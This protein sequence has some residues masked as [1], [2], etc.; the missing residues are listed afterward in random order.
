MPSWIPI[1][2]IALPVWSATTETLRS[3][4]QVAQRDAVRAVKGYKS[5]DSTTDLMDRM[6]ITPVEKRWKEHDTT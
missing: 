1:S 6:K 4:L 3:S 5:A 2:T